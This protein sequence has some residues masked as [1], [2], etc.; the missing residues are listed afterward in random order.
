[1]T[2]AICRIATLPFKL[3]GLPLRIARAIVGE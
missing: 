3:L 1:V 2:N